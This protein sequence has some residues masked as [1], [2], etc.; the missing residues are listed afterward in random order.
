MP[1][2]A[3]RII[4]QLGELVATPSVSS[5]S[6]TWDQGNRQIIDLL[7]NWCES[8]GFTV[9]VMPVNDSGSKANMLATRGQGPGGLVLAGHSDTVPYDEHHW[10]SD[11]LILTERDQRLYGLGASDMKG[12][13]PLALSAAQ[14]VM[15]KE[16]AQPLMIL[17]T[18]DEES[19]MSGARA[20]AAQ[21]F[22]T[23][24]AAVIGEPTGLRPVRMHKG[25][26]MQ[27][28]RVTG[29]AGH[30]SNPAL[31]N[32]AL[33]A[34]H[35][36]IS[37]LMVFRQK[38]QARYRNPLFE[39]AMPT[40]NLGCLH[41]GD[42]P[43]R[44]CG[45]AELHFDLRLLP[46]SDT[47]AV[48]G[49]LRERL[50]ARALETG[51]EIAMTSLIG[52]VEPFEQSADSELIGVAEKLSGYSAEVVNFATEAPFMQQLGMQTVVMGPG[53]IDQA[54]QPDEFL[55]LDQLMPC[56]E[57]LEGLIKHYCLA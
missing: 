1:T 49:D 48:L 56:I 24:R 51:T 27:S 7:A 20:L 41:G 10:Q 25:M 31:G 2:E 8:L 50:S 40:M 29:Q 5:T 32:S 28:V 14:S 23:A 9:Q 33:E 43:N 19:S 47:D 16:L 38:L 18:A 26:A 6:A 17:A 13:F 21:G 35:A 34:M 52:G 55:A 42:N 15:D 36:V 12:F 45:Q 46:G 11:P 4:R 39:V 57:L 44:I 53:S 22:P 37:D 3:Q 30:S 54:H